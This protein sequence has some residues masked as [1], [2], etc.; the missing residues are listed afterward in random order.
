MPDQ[1]KHLMATTM[2]Q[3]LADGRVKKAR[4]RWLTAP[5]IGSGAVTLIF[6]LMAL[7]AQWVAPED[8]L[9]LFSGRVLQGPSADHW[10]G[11]DELA[12]D[13]LSRLIYGAQTSLMVSFSAVFISTMIGASLGTIAGYAGGM[14]D[15]FIMR[16][17]D[18]ILC[19]PSMIL[20]IAVVAFLGNTIQNLIIVMGILY[21]PGTARIAYSTTLSIKGMDYVE[22]AQMV[23]APSYRIIFRHILPNAVAPLLVHTA[24]NLGFVILTESGLSFLGMGPPPPTPSWGQMIAIGRRYIHRQPLLLLTPMVTVSIIIVAF[25][26]LSDSLRDVLD[27]RVRK[28]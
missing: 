7:L 12:R 24:L 9:K 3:S 26:I 15:M 4:S 8:P 20:A 5:L 19:F 6:I 14:V 10:L 25:T 11:T 13:I 18:V 27:P 2:T 23:G 16:M 22:S 1:E 21:I 17:M 28:R